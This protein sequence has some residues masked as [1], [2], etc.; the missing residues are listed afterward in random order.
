MAIRII[1]SFLR[2]L[3]YFNYY[4]NFRGKAKNVILSGK[5]CIL[6]PHEISLGE[7]IF[8]GRG[9]YISA[10]NLEFGSN[11]MIGPNLLIECSNHRYDT[12]GKS[13]Y[14]YSNA[15]SSQGIRIEDD[16]WIGGNVT[17]LDGVTI[18]EGCVIGACSN[19][20]KSLPPYTI[21]V[22]N[23]CKPLKKRFDDTDLAKHLASVNSRY[24]IGQIKNMRNP[25]FQI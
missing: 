2:H 15:K 8:I 10:T 20:T 1:R 9:F 3:Y 24:P 12:I 5:G 13:M 22:G 11:I 4:R 7:N 17:I 25:F 21:C 16:V 19:V 14:S 23:P 18:G 6:R